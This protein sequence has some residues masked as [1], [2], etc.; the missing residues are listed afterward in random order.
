[1]KVTTYVRC[2]ATVRF[3]ETEG[4]YETSKTARREERFKVRTISW[5][6][7]DRLVRMRGPVIKKD[8]SEGLMNRER[9]RP[10]DDLPE[11]IKTALIASMKVAIADLRAEA[12]AL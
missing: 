12:G 1:M 7:G 8:G 10:F 6:M 2:S 4:W 11:H 3:D 9:F 5:P